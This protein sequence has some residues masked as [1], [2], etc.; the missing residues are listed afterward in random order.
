MYPAQFQFNTVPTTLQKVCG[1]NVEGM[2][3]FVEAMLSFVEAML[4]NVEAM[5]VHT[6]NSVQL[7][8]S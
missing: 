2:L 5:L 6:N 7:S 8:S 3:R 1:A 4:R